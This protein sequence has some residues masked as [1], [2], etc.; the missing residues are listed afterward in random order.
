[1]TKVYVFSVGR[2]SFYNDKAGGLEGRITQGVTSLAPFLV[3]LDAKAKCYLFQITCELLLPEI[4]VHRGGYNRE[5]VVMEGISR[6]LA[7]EVHCPCKIARTSSQGEYREILKERPQTALS[8]IQ[9]Q[10]LVA[11][12]GL[13][14]GCGWTWT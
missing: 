11:R 2:L 3:A 4:E 5:E 6:R 14:D 9:G 1:M 7:S 12:R 10:S 13:L 8:Y